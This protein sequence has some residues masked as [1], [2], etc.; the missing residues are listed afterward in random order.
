LPLSV[1]IYPQLYGFAVKKADQY[2]AM[3]L[4]HSG[5]YINGSTLFHGNIL[6]IN[7]IQQSGNAQP[8]N[9]V[10]LRLIRSY[11]ST[12][13]AEYS[14]NGTLFITFLDGSS[15]YKYGLILTFFDN[16]YSCHQFSYSGYT[17][18]QACSSSFATKKKSSHH[19][20]KYTS[21]DYTHEETIKQFPN[22]YSTQPKPNIPQKYTSHLAIYSNVFAYLYNINSQYFIT[23]Y[24]FNA[25]GC[26]STYYYIYD[27]Y[28][29]DNLT[30]LYEGCPENNEIIFIGLDK[31]GRC[32]A[33]MYQYQPSN[34]FKTVKLTQTLRYVFETD[35][36]IKVVY[37][38]DSYFLLF[39][40]KELKRYTT[41]DCQIPFFKLSNIIDFCK[42]EDYLMVFR[43][44]NTIG[45]YD[46]HS[47]QTT[48]LIEDISL[49]SGYN[50]YK[51]VSF[52]VHYSNTLNALVSLFNPSQPGNCSIAYIYRSAT[53]K[54]VIEFIPLMFAPTE[55]IT[56][57]SLYLYFAIIVT[58]KQMYSYRYMYNTIH[59]SLENSNFTNS[60]SYLIIP[61]NDTK[62]AVQVQVSIPSQSI[63]QCEPTDAIRI[64][65]LENN[66]ISLFNYLKF[67]D[68]TFSTN[69]A[70]SEYTIYYKNLSSYYIVPP[71]SGAIIGSSIFSEYMY[72]ADAYGVVKYTY[73]DDNWTIISE[74][75]FDNVSA[76]MMLVYASGDG[77]MFAILGSKNSIFKLSIQQSSN[78]KLFEKYAEDFYSSINI[79]H[80]SSINRAMRAN[81]CYQ[82]HWA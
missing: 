4:P 7:I 43:N 78:N 22:S 34:N 63:E 73:V 15:V 24:N 8:T 68:A 5:I 69:I 2:S 21:Y 70:R 62:N 37:I 44:D 3:A 81:R 51:Y 32:V 40:S 77:D 10:N 39:Q 52:V 1:T 79:F 67:F 47:Y 65:G 80:R 14:K 75:S 18:V 29:Y 28:A 42:F 11:D 12:S 38:F 50:L 23:F 30:L 31:S 25:D 82:D 20:S 71:L 19:Y 6:S 45:I 61:N 41:I 13:F 33:Y 46:V 48:Y 49:P 64:T 56:Y 72:V 27:T 54:I 53:S 9:V 36:V 58:N 57:V 26:I 76:T 17:G 55:Y 66:L 60:Y 35:I 74:S 59:I 16:N